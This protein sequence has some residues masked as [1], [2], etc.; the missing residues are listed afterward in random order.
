MYPGDAYVDFIGADNYDAS[1]SGSYAPTDHA[2]VWAGILGGNYGLDWLTAFA[3]QHGKRMSLPEWGMAYKCDG[4]GG[5]DDPYFIDQI[6]NWV[7]T[8]NVAY[9]SYFE[10]NDSDCAQFSLTSGHFPNGAAEYQKMF[11]KPFASSTPPTTAPAPA[12][13]TTVAPAPTT[14]VAPAP[15]TTV[16]PAPT[17]TVAPA[18][19][20]TVAPAPT[21]TVAPAPT[22]TVAPAPTTTVAPAPAPTTTVAPAPTTTVA[23][24]KTATPAPAPTTTV[25]PTKSATPAPTTPPATAKPTPPAPVA[26]SLMLS[27]SPDRSW[28]AVLNKQ[29]L[30]HNVYIYYPDS[31]TVAKVVFSIDGKVYHSESTPAWDLA[32]TAVTGANAFSPKTLTA[33]AHTV[34]ATVTTTSGT[35]L[36]AQSTFY[37]PASVAKARAVKATASLL[38]VSASP[39]GKAIRKLDGATINRHK[40]VRL[41]VAPGTV[42][43][44][45]IFDSKVIR[46]V[47]TAAHKAIVP[48][49]TASLH[50]GKHRLVI[51]MVAKSG[52]L[53][54]AAAVF[55]IA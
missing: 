35:T 33:G 54:V 52:Q 23:P 10:A 43:A 9:E 1:Y 26:A 19:T 44:E 28:P 5:G 34:L 45:F 55:K 36:K 37:V 39:T 46:V 42:R 11:S 17:T 40:F 13:T 20:T 4:H 16:A 25:A 49:R 30:D 14:T 7:A 32:G 27:Y 2:K 3:A 12:P 38:S 24:T 21:T 51:R 8:H 31:K 47:R 50:K 53:S 29:S 15:T 22:T 41:S 18:P 6:H 48:I